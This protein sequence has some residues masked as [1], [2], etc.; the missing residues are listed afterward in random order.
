MGGTASL[1][2]RAAD[3]ACVTGTTC[4]AAACVECGHARFFCCGDTV[5]D[6]GTC[7]AGLVCMAGR[8]L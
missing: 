8:C 4:W 3:D 5:G 7:D 1:A 2:F 6:T